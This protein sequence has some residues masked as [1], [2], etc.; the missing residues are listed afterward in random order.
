MTRR[1]PSSRSRAGF[2]LI[3]LMGV[4]VVAGLLVGIVALD[5]RSMVPRTQLN[6]AVRELAATIQGARSDA[7][8]RN[9]MFTLV[10]DLEA[11]SYHVLSPLRVGGGLARTYEERAVVRQGVLPDGVVL[12]RVGVDGREFVTEQVAVHFDPFGRASGHTV[13]LVQPE[14][15]GRFTIEVIGLTGLVRFHDGDFQ[16]EEVFEEDF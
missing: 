3:E 16:R 4:V 14:F 9:G 2:S 12:E 7:I 10:Y 8:A 13:T 15:G 5:W 1:Q 6:A 11:N